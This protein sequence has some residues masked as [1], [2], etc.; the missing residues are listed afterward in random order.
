MNFAFFPYGP[1][2]VLLDALVSLVG[3]FLAMG[4]WR[5]LGV[6]NGWSRGHQL[7]WAWLVAVVVT[8]GADTWHLFY[9]NIIPMESTV[10]IRHVLATIHDPDTLGVRVV[11]EFASVSAGVVCG[12]LVWGRWGGD[13]P[14]R[15]TR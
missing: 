4:T 10:I 9:S 8:A 6:R 7:G 13:R 3:G 1:W 11:C 14:A 12:W 15:L 5:W 2:G